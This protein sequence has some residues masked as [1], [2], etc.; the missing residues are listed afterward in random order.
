MPK[1]QFLEAGQVVG[2]H[3]IH[4]E[5]RVQSWCDS[6]EVFCT[7]KKLYWDENGKESFKVKSRPQKNIVLMKAEGID[8][9]PQ[10]EE[11]R[12]KIVYLNRKDL[13]LPKDTYFVQDLIGMKILDVDTSEQ[14]GI[15][16]DVSPT[17]ANNVYHMKTNDGKEVLIPAIP[18][19]VK[20]VDFDT[21]SIKIFVIKGLLDDDEN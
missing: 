21:D 15:L 20:Q 19:V 4:G 9:I 10:A 5:M 17:G 14:L 1:K 8:T 7:L 2:T 13:K 16:I 12:N 11:Y 3:G 18:L 6:V